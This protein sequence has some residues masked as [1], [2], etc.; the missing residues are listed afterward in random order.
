[1]NH[2]RL[3]KGWLAVAGLA[4]GEAV[5]AF[6][7]QPVISATGSYPAQGGNCVAIIRTSP[8]GGF[9]QLYIGTDASTQSTS[10]MT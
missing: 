4:I 9:K 2:L 7:G 6:A 10:Q 3:L 1:M 8:N 5:A